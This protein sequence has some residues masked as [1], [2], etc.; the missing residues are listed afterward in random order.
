MRKYALSLV[1]LL[2][3]FSAH[4]QTAD[5]VLLHG[6]ILTVDA[7]DSI[8]QA[9]AVSQGKILAVGSDQQILSLAGPKTERIDLHGR[10]ATPGL[11]DTHA[12][13]AEGGVDELYA[14]SLSDATSGSDVVERGQGAAAKLPPGQ[15]V[16]GS[17]WDEGKLAERR[18]ILASDL[19]RAAPHN[20]VW[21]VHTTGHYGGATP[22]AVRGADI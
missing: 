1:C 8:A 22:Q 5:L 20:P 3:A 12:H 10:T 14:V 16:T 6:K 2:C 15:W 7:K 19:D 9:L 11:I 13:L 4:A 18:Y 17:G 21:L